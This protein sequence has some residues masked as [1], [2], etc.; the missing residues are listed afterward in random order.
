MKNRF[1][2]S[3]I[4]VAGLLLAGFPGNSVYGQTQQ[5][6]AMH[7][8]VKYTCPMHPEVIKDKPGKCP[9]CGMPLV[10]KK[11]KQQSAKTY[12]CKMHPE[13]VMNKPGKC[14][15]CGMPLVEK[16]DKG[17]MMNMNAPSRMKDSM[18]MK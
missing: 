15:K 2:Y 12:T 9:K 17:K 8:V 5:A 4:L 6:P 7:K 18:K 13:I 10:E 1:I 14:P 3:L 11:E 16:L